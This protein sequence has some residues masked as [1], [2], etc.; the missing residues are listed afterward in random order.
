MW[1]MAAPTQETES[2]AQEHRESQ[3]SNLPGRVRALTSQGWPFLS[4]RWSQTR[5][6]RRVSEFVCLLSR[7]T[8][9]A[10]TS[11]EQPFLLTVAS[12]KVMQGS[13]NISP[14]QGR[15]GTF[16]SG[17]S[18]QIRPRHTN[19]H[20]KAPTSTANR[21]FFRTK[22]YCVFHCAYQYSGTYIWTTVC[23]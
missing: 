17:V 22:K 2:P 9:I 7:N 16:L 20:P 1:A 5:T 8:V 15:Q 12:W 14:F 23:R 10:T 6:S 18:Q 11:L 19:R 3:G 4:S 21:K 13:S